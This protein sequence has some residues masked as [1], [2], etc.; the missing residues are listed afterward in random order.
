[1]KRS[2]RRG[3][4]RA[5]CATHVVAYRLGCGGGEVG[6]PWPRGA[7]PWECNSAVLQYPISSAPG[8]IFWKTVAAHNIRRVIMLHLK[9]S[10]LSGWGEAFINGHLA[11]R[12]LATRQMHRPWARPTVAPQAGD[13]SLSPL[14]SHPAYLTTGSAVSSSHLLARPLLCPGPMGQAPAKH[15]LRV[16]VARRLC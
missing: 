12:R 2:V 8:S 6:A 7:A 3:M 4:P 9:H 16:E 1:L 11:D 5:I 14:V 15:S 10:S 13:G